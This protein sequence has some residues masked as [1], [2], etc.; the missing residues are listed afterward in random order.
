MWE[1]GKSSAAVHLASRHEILD[2]LGSVAFPNFINPFSFPYVP[3]AEQFA[4]HSLPEACLPISFKRLSN[5]LELFFHPWPLCLSYSH[6]PRGRKSTSKVSIGLCQLLIFPSCTLFTAYSVQCP[7]QWGVLPWQWWMERLPTYWSWILILHEPS[8]SFLFSSECKCFLEQNGLR[9]PV[10]YGVPQ[11]TLQAE[12]HFRYKL[13]V[14]QRER[15]N[16]G[17]RM[18]LDLQFLTSSETVK[19]FLPFI[20]AHL[21]RCLWACFTLPLAMSHRADSGTHLVRGEKTACLLAPHVFHPTYMALA[22]KR[23]SSLWDFNL[24]WE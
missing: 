4:G 24:Y 2:R 22:K 18:C 5:I 7:V 3:I 23:R 11:I 21:S 12:H 9:H 10:D 16:M 15:E 20:L 8:V 17:G 14:K 19:S 13:E 6:I 1:E